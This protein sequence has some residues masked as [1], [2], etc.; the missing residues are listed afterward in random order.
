M[1]AKWHSYLPQRSTLSTSPLS[2]EMRA[3]LGPVDYVDL[4]DAPPLPGP[5]PVAAP[6]ACREG[7][8]DGSSQGHP[9]RGAAVSIQP[10]TDTIWMEAERNRSPDKGPCGDD[11]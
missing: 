3:L 8:G 11:S 9:S 4:K 1:L 7:V 10:D 6:T 2:L 5:I